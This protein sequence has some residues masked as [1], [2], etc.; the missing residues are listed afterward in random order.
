MD[1]HLENLPFSVPRCTSG[2]PVPLSL[3]SS[4]DDH[5]VVGSGWISDDG[6]PQELCIDLLQTSDL[7]EISL[8]VHEIHTPESITI[9]TG[10]NN[11]LV[12]VLFADLEER[13]GNTNVREQASITLSPP[14]TKIE[15]L[16]F[17][18]QGDTRKGIVRIS[19]R[20]VPLNHHEHRA[21]HHGS[22]HV[23]DTELHSLGLATLSEAYVHAGGTEG[24][25]TILSKLDAA[26][27]TSTGVILDMLRK[28]KHDMIRAHAS[29]AEINEEEANRLSHV[30]KSFDRVGRSISRVYHA[31]KQAVAADE[32]GIAA[33]ASDKLQEC[34]QA[35]DF[36][37]KREALRTWCCGGEDSNVFEKVVLSMIDTGWGQ[38]T[39]GLTVASPW[40]RAMRAAPL[41]TLPFSMRQVSETQSNKEAT[42]AGIESS[43]NDHTADTAAAGD[44]TPSQ[45][46]AYEKWVKNLLQFHFGSDG[47]LYAQGIK[48]PTKLAG[49]NVLSV[50]F[51]H[52]FGQYMTQCLMDIKAWVL[53]QASLAVIALTCEDETGWLRKHLDTKRLKPVEF[54]QVT[55]RVLI[56][57]AKDPVLAV[58]KQVIE[59]TAS[60]F[61]ILWTNEDE[62]C[63]IAMPLL[64]S[65]VVRITNSPLGT[66]KATRDVAV[67]GLMF[68]ANECEYIGP[69]KVAHALYQ[70]L[71]HLD[72]RSRAS[73]FEH[74]LKP[75]MVLVDRFGCRND[76]TL[77]PEDQHLSIRSLAHLSIELGRSRHAEVTQLAQDI[78][79]KMYSID[80]SNNGKASR[81]ALNI[82]ED[83]ASLALYRTPKF[84]RQ[85]MDIDRKLQRTVH[86][87]DV[88]AMEGR[89]VNDEEEDDNV[90]ALKQQLAEMKAMMRQAQG[91][92]KKK[93][94]KKKKKKTTPKTTTTTK[95]P[96]N[97]DGGDSGDGG[98]GEKKK[99]KNVQPHPPPEEADME[100]VKKE[101]GMQEETEGMKETEEIDSKEE[102][103][104]DAKVVTKEDVKESK[105]KIEE[106][107][108]VEVDSLTVNQQM[109]DAKK[110]GQLRQGKKTDEPPASVKK[111]GSN[112]DETKSLD[113]FYT[114]R[115]DVGPTTRP[116]LFDKFDNFKKE[117]TKKEETKK[118][119][120]KVKVVESPALVKKKVKIMKKIRDLKL[121]LLQL[122]DTDVEERESAEQKIAK[123]SKRLVT[124]TEADVND[125]AKE[126]LPKN[127][128]DDDANE[129]KIV[130]AGDN[131]GKGK[132][133][134]MALKKL[135][136][137]ATV[138]QKT[139]KKS[140]KDCVV[141]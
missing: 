22:E 30:F 138:V 129:A 28:K 70:A 54:F 27:D 7:H 43:S 105:K 115:T 2:D 72:A 103:N 92:G 26:T 31:K 98:D 49:T 121:S 119:V 50:P 107:L 135:K 113:E 122:E 80:I 100:A 68:L 40:I 89:G 29:S 58:F 1:V 75:Y 15:T 132:G 37:A 48:L 91:G 10:T 20:G 55:A 126:S 101:A 123:L 74:L 42:T 62:Q 19:L 5:E 63:H 60:L 71:H 131:E 45:E 59:T 17:V 94:Q 114:D 46:D 24:A 35:R 99:Q 134:S 65:F 88:R 84:V 16:R 118:E 128:M 51:M 47:V 86:D 120:A 76:P 79:L 21:H 4:L 81:D 77:P 9:F 140:K 67:K 25:Q 69:V 102:K 95:L 141:Q 34:F 14:C 97:S 110:V 23:V 127:G 52:V 61:S 136:K 137:V 124:L 90:R 117:E 111:E 44:S 93:Q 87:C 6:G 11:L 109:E 32:F 78:A 106:T 125:D 38:T 36:L 41:F 18:L 39:P 12:K 130:V 8:L 133:K 96:V 56:Y 64:R 108:E 3:S 73:S 83:G 112:M 13:G 66:G 139:G 85:M 57:M 104:K 116:N 53:R 33:A 82:R